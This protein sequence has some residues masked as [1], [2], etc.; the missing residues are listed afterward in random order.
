VIPSTCMQ[1]LGPCKLCYS[2]RSACQP[3]HHRTT[4][5]ATVTPRYLNAGCAQGHLGWCGS[6][7][8]R[9]GRTEDRCWGA[10][11]AHWGG[12]VPISRTAAAEAPDRHCLSRSLAWRMRHRRLAPCPVRPPVRYTIEPSRA[13]GGIRSL[14]REEVAEEA[15]DEARD[16]LVCRFAFGHAG[17]RTILLPSDRT[18]TTNGH[19][20][21]AFKWG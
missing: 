3:G 1:L 14:V 8:N 17:P 18:Q 15:R 5:R 12:D 4:V 13:E 10:V 11:G 20:G 19:G 9:G 21:D 6:Y 2:T 7:T 16:I